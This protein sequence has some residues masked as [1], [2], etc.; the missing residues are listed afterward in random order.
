MNSLLSYTPTTLLATAILVLSAITVFKIYFDIILNDILF[1]FVKILHRIMHHR[2]T[3]QNPKPLGPVFTKFI[4]C[5][6]S[7]EI[8]F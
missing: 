3:I 4:F 2:R 6:F 8:L 7:I 5:L 1:S